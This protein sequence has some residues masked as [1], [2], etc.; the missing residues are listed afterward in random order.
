M[1][2]R[3]CLVWYARFAEGRGGPCSPATLCPR[4]SAPSS[5]RCRCM[6]QKSER[7]TKAGAERCRAA[8]DCPRCVCT[9]LT[10]LRGCRAHRGVPTSQHARGR[11][12]GVQRRRLR[13]WSSR[14]SAASMLRVK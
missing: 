10:N 11:E 12:V 13:H 6:R 1:M 14:K 4:A 9:M 7:D 3:G 8:D 5:C 2:V